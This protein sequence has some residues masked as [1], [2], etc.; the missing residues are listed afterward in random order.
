MA[1]EPGWKVTH[2]SALNLSRWD[3]VCSNALRGVKD[4]LPKLSTDKKLTI[5]DIGANTGTFS[6]LMLNE[7]PYK[8]KRMLL[9]EPVPLYARWAAFK[10]SCLL[11]DPSVEIMEY[12]LSDEKG[13]GKIAINSKDSNFGWNTMVK[14]WQKKD[15]FE[16][17]IDVPTISFDEVYPMFQLD[18]IDLIK[19]DVEG[20]EAKVLNG[21][22]GTLKSL[23]DK[24]P[25]TVEI[26]GGSKHFEWSSKTTSKHHDDMGLQDTLSK[27]KNIGYHFRDVS[28]WPDKT[29]DLVLAQEGAVFEERQSEKKEE[30]LIE[31]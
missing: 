3:V 14:D 19:I 21:M 22:I 20:Y 30:D 5:I 1:I 27:F 11:R 13:I 24:P 17:M 28:E 8:F 12:A 23:D 2:K 9:F 10:F 25:I 6:E 18:G 31:V 26:A 4:K 15:D 7:S 16:T 29:F